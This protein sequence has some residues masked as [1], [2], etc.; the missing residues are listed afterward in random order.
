[1]R[2]LLQH[3]R[4]QLYLRGLGD[5]TANPYDAFD[6][7]HTQKAI[8]FARDHGLTGVQIAVKFVDSECDEVAA[9]PPLT[10]GTSQPVY[11]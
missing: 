3:T 1:M 8:T 9:I 4:T 10:P 2:I 5:W 7:Q 11:R 6:F